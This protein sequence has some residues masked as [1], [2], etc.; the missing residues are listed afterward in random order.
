MSYYTKTL[1][2]Y[3]KQLVEDYASIKAGVKDLDVRDLPDSELSVFASHMFQLDDR[4]MF[5][6]YENLAYEAIAK[7][8]SEMLEKPGDTFRTIK[9]GESIRLGMI[10]Y[11]IPRMQELVDNIIMRGYHDNDDDYDDYKLEHD[12]HQSQEARL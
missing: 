9:F 7:H 1:Y 12:W 6:I 2:P 5:S 4:D 8:L 11:Y 10:E 3:L